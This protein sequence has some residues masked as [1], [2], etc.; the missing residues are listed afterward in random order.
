M[1]TQDLEPS[2]KDSQGQ[3]HNLKLKEAT[4]FNLK[5]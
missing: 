1:A 4:E 2:P 3:Q 5:G